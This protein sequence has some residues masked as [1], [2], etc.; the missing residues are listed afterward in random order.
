MEL[1]ATSLPFIKVLAA[2]SVMLAGIRF[3]IG[4]GL[5]ILLGSLALGFMFGLGPLQWAE[6]GAVALVQEKFLLLAAIV[7]LILILSDALE[8]SGQSRRLMDAISGYLK[9][10]RLRLAFFPA[11]IGLLPMPGGAIFSAP[12]LKSVSERMDIGDMDRATLNYWFRHIWELA[13]P[14]YPGMILT[15][16]LADLP[17]LSIISRTGLGLPIMM[18]L[19]WIFFLRPGVLPAEQLV[20]ED[21]EN[22]R[23][24][25]R[26]VVEGLPLVIAIV[27]GLGLEGVIASF[28]P[29]LP[30][31]LGVIAALVAAIGCIMAQN[32]LGTGFLKS[33]LAKKGLHSMLFVIVSIFVFKDVMHA[34][35]VVDAMAR[36]AGGEA[37]LLASA[38]FLPFLVGMVSGINVAFVGATFP[39]LIGVL[40]TLNMQD[41]LIP[42][43]VLGSFC[44]F[45]GVM[46]SPIHI[47]FI[48]TCEYFGVNLAAAWRRVVV[49]CLLLI[50]CGVAWFWIL[51]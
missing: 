47:C 14:L 20:A 3:K 6:A 42:Y 31:E 49:P 4:L 25:R 16:A 10:P 35:H 18:T 17:I 36:A 13:W 2:F 51:K 28:L 46:I 1:L 34:A 48:L 29:W 45:A 43:V 41:Q 37:A 50:S 12:M 24:W 23:D 32:R 44:G 27:G 39:L 15:A 19:G 38:V 7:G 22:G 21:S 30:F 33:V 11:L 26:A 8:R 40:Q 9:S 5:S